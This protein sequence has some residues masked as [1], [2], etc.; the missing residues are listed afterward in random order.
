MRKEK[1]FAAL[2]AVLFTVILTLG[3]GPSQARERVGEVRPL[4][5]ESPHPI[6]GTG[7]RTEIRAEGATFLRLRLGAV[8]PGGNQS[9]IPRLSWNC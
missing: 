6:T 9:A 3:S 7:W 4:R 8:E 1:L 5:V 2:T